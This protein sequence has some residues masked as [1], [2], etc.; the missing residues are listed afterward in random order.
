MSSTG[1]GGP[2]QPLSRECCSKAC[3]AVAIETKIET[4]N[5]LQLSAT[6]RHRVDQSL[7]PQPCGHKSTAARL[8]EVWI[9][10]RDGNP[11]VMNRLGS[12]PSFAGPTAG[13]DVSRRRAILTRAA[14]LA[15]GM[16]VL[17]LGAA[18][19]TSLDRGSGTPG[20]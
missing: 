2:S 6:P 17:F 4:H 1:R 12:V 3:A 20:A 19:I 13:A 11:I 9:R 8:P 5:S 10:I 16:V 15:P 14:W 18:W 7:P